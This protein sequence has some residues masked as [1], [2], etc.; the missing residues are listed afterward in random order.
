MEDWEEAFARMRLGVGM[1]P[2]MA[3]KAS[4]TIVIHISRMHLTIDARL[5]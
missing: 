4:G 1:M 3:L 2:E 5:T